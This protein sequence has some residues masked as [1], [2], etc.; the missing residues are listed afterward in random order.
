MFNFLVSC[1]DEV[2]WF[3]PAYLDMLPSGLIA[4]EI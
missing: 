1:F 2:D 4:D 3:V